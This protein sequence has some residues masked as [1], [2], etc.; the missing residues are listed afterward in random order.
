MLVFVIN[1]NLFSN[2]QGVLS[3]CEDIDKK[4][5]RN[6]FA[7]VYPL[8]ANLALSADLALSAQS[9]RTK[10]SLLVLSTETPDWVAK[11]FS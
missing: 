10:P 7:I 6:Y 3:L 5:L 4:R 11:L 8:S 1:F 9:S 2:E